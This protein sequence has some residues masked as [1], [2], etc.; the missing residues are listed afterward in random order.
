MQGV[1]L[2]T[3]ELDL[4]NEYINTKTFSYNKRGFID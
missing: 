1:D 4:L 2:D 3:D